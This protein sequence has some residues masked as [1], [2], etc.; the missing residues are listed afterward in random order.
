MIN[1]L[2]NDK[3]KD[4]YKQILEDIQI[5]SGSQNTSEVQN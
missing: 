4:I 3:P 2:G 5:Q 1:A